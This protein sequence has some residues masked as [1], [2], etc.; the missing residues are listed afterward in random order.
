MTPSP[1][2]TSYSTDPFH[3][4]LARLYASLERWK[5]PRLRLW[6]GEDRFPGFNF[7]V[8]VMK[9]QLPLLKSQGVTHFI[10]V[11]GWDT[12]CCGPMEEVIPHCGEGILLAGEIN[13]YPHP[14]K[15]SRYPEAHKKSR[16]CHVNGGS[17]LTS[18]EFF[19][20]VVVPFHDKG[21]FENDQ[22]MFTELYLTG[23]PLVKVDSG[24]EVFQTL[25]LTEPPRDFRLLPSGGLFN[26]ET[27]THPAFVH[28][29]GRGELTWIDPSWERWW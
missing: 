15:T 13:C 28:A 23:N 20:D 24:C 10:T 8:E 11:D 16:F 14:E 17:I 12:L 1:V 5:W 7:K 18:L 27:R 21:G 6:S 2:V 26:L 19:A 29:N 22:I 25:Y 9:A 3:P 4:C